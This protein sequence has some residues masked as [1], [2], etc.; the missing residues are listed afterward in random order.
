MYRFYRYKT[1]RRHYDSNKKFYVCSSGGCGSQMICHYLGNF[2]DVYHLH[3]R[4][5]PEKLTNTGYD[6]DKTYAEWFSQIEIPDNELYKYKVIFLYRDPIEVIYSRYIN[7]PA[8]LKNVQCNDINVTIKD[9]LRENK[10]LFGLEEFFNN[11]TSESSKRNYP[12]YCVK[13]EEFW[14]NIS[15][16]NQTLSVSN[17]LKLYPVREERKK[18]Q[19][20][21]KEEVESLREIYKPLNNRIT[22][23]RFIELR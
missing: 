20:R 7:C 11:Y 15:L 10:D 3:S 16:F 22:N 12:I 17:I 18:Q 6:D 8:M 2:G 1:D 5:P 9:C 23:M 21:D 14:N 4:Y 13:Y 19:E